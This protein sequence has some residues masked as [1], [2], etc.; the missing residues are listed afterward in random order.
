MLLVADLAQSYI[1]SNPLFAL[2]GADALPI[3]DQG[4]FYGSLN[5]IAFWSCAF[6]L[7]SAQYFFLAAGAVALG[8]SEPKYWPDFFGKWSDTYTLRRFW[9]CVVLL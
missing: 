8:I 3:Q 9:G 5:I 6:S 7:M 4:Y 1:H 2:R